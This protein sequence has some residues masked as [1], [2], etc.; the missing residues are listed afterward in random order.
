MATKTE[1]LSQEIVDKLRKLQSDSNDVIFELGQVEVRFLDL[2]K[3]KKSLEDSFTKIKIELDEI[4]KDL[5][6]K[7]P[8]GEVSLQEGT[9][10]FEE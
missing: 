5:E 2:T 7:Y 9:V 4:L 6:N 3:Y 10:T 1:Q 8:N